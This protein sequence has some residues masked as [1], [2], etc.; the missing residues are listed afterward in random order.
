MRSH[1][2]IDGPGYQ[3]K[4]YPIDF[5]QIAGNLKDC[6]KQFFDYNEIGNIYLI[7]HKVNSMTTNK[8]AHFSVFIDIGGR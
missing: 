8:C 1:Y 3:G 6:P 4:P 7:Q 2:R 5:D